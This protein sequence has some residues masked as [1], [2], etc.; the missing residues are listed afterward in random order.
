M[1]GIIIAVMAI[2][3]LLFRYFGVNSIK[4]FVG[5]LRA[6]Y[7]SIGNYVQTQGTSIY[8]QC[9]ERGRYGNTPPPLV[10]TKND[11][12]DSSRTQPEC[13]SLE[14]TMRRPL[15][16]AFLNEDDYPPNWMIYDGKRGG[17]IEYSVYRDLQLLDSTE[18]RQ[19]CNN[20]V[21]AMTTTTATAPALSTID[22]KKRV[23][24]L[25]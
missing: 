4:Y 8:A 24:V 9:N 6:Y 3:I 7:R 16:P 5:I 19:H 10:C 12:G 21:P 20:T 22:G 2:A 23:N 1:A 13:T 18:S 17:V 11:K 25:H 14:M 15:E